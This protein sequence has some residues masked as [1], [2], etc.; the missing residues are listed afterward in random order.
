MA[1]V[2]ER[3]AERSEERATTLRRVLVAPDPL[4]LSDAEV[5]EIQPSPAEV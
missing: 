3:E 2:Y 5:D 4:P 1:D